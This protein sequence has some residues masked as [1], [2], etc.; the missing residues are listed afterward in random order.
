MQPTSPAPGASVAKTIL[1]V[2]DYASVRF[3]HANLLRQAGYKTLDARDGNE[4]LDK[5]RQNRVDLILLDLIMP[6]MSG[7]EFIRRLRAIPEFTNIPLLIVSSEAAEDKI[8][9]I[10]GSGHFGFAIKPIVPGTLLDS[11]RKLIA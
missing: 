5:V 8:R 2:D 9:A 11:V 3:Y 6:K 7:E 1:V 4:A 10:A